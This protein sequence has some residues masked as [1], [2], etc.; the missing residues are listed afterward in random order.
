[1]VRLILQLVFSRPEQHPARPAGEESRA[2]KTSKSM[3]NFDMVFKVGKNHNPRCRMGVC[4]QRCNTTYPN[5][6]LVSPLSYLAVVDHTPE[7][8]TECAV[9]NFRLGHKC[10][11]VVLQVAALACSIAVATTTPLHARTAATSCGDFKGQE[12]CID[13]APVRLNPNPCLR[14]QFFDCLTLYAFN[15]NTVLFWRRSP[16]PEFYDH[17]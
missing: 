14:K 11:F 3:T 5:F 17:G 7:T 15:F 2:S 12:A 6:P 1:M 10:G 9:H 4:L 8:V 16:P 13:E